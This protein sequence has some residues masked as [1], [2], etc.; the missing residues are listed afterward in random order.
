MNQRVVSLEQDVLE[1]VVERARAEAARG[2]VVFDLDST[3]LDN[4]P[5]QARILRE[6]GAQHGLPALANAKPEHW[7]SWDL[8]RA[9]GNAGLDAVEIE[10][11]SD[12]AKTFWRE[13]FFTSEYC[14][15]D[16][17][18]RGAVRF[19]GEIAGSGALVAYCTGRPEAMREGTVACFR[20]LGFSVPGP[21]VHLLMKPALEITDDE[22]KTSADGQLH[23][24]G[25]VIAVFDNEPTHVNG[26]RA[27]FPDAFCVHLATDDSGRDVTLTNG[28][29]SISHF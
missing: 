17:A 3:L 7:D 16:E 25:R 29:V 13:R 22:W 10:H 24:L 1:R 23:R 20:R 2:V 8:E 18:I 4:R 11:W 21:R 14:A 15:D 27:A 28:I 9:M 19:V 12:A 6:F 5:R 26:Y